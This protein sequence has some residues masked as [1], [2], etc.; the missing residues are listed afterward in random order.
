MGREF[1]QNFQSEQCVVCVL[2]QIQSP[3]P[4]LW[5]QS[6]KD[7]YVTFAIM[8]RRDS[9]GAIFQGTTKI[10]IPIILAP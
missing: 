4:S 5:D 9:G 6:H 10:A 7:G 8:G 2:L 1:L 3:L